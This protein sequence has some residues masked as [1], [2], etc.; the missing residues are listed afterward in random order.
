MSK[1]NVVLDN[2]TAPSGE[3]GALK[4]G[5]N[6]TGSVQFI[7]SSEVNGKL[8]VLGSN[9]GVHYDRIKRL[10]AKAGANDVKPL[11]MPLFLKFRN[12]KAP[13]GP[14]TIIVVNDD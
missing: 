6:L 4:P 13:F 3:F 2:K 10:Q 11:R 12:S 5:G 9:D 14:V 7:N 1:T 8:T